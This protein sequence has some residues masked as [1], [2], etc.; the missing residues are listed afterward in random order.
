MSELIHVHIGTIDGNFPVRRLITTGSFAGCYETQQGPDT[1]AWVHQRWCSEV[2]D[3]GDF[4]KSP[5]VTVDTDWRKF[6]HDHW[7]QDRNMLNPDYAEEF[8]HVFM[9]AQQAWKAKQSTAPVEAS[10]PA[11]SCAPSFR[12][13][14]KHKLYPDEVIKTKKNTW[15]QLSLF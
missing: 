9:A 8:M 7:L 3:N 15:I 5:S 2:G 14:K 6:L 4:Q 11:P 13:E 12:A 1:V 10:T